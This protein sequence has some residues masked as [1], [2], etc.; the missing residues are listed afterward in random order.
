MIAPSV[1]VAL[2]LAP[3]A[4]P[5]SQVPPVEVVVEAPDTA[6]I[7]AMARSL[8]E[9]GE[10]SGEATPAE[11]QTPAVVPEDAPREGDDGAVDDRTS[12]QEQ[13]SSRTPTLSAGPPS[14]LAGTPEAALLASL[15]R[16][17]M[18]R[19]EDRNAWG[20]LER[21]AGPWIAA[22]PVEEGPA[23][24][25]GESGVENPAAS[26]PR[27]ALDVFSTADDGRTGEPEAL[28]VSGAAPGSSGAWAV[29]EGS[30]AVE[31]SET[32]PAT[33]MRG[34]R[35]LVEA[36]R[37]AVGAAWAQ[38]EPR[39]LVGVGALRRWTRQGRD[40]L[41]R[42]GVDERLVA[43]TALGLALVLLGLRMALR[44]LAV[45]RARRA[46]D[47]TRAR[48]RRR[49]SVRAAR[50]LV[51]RGAEPAQI[52]RRTGVSQDALRILT[53]REASSVTDRLFVKG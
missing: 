17:V 15:V 28:R 27:E 41:A 9:Q 14:T 51:S 4:A 7:R 3:Q 50:L 2:L 35:G 12:A 43:G 31:A 49:T 11:G 5:A 10:T 1:L 45:S 30:G 36:G 20:A 53:D 29:R 16:S 33:G 6:V 52:A 13:D 40:A 47:W 37:V 38:A 34:W 22:A 39:I 32:S 24:G 26:D 8:I 25:T 23:P 21:R 44:R 42:Q 19:P 18:A 48:L 46:A